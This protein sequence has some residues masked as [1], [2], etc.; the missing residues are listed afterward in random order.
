MT[1]TNETTKETKQAQPRAI[2]NRIDIYESG[3]DVPVYLRKPLC[4]QCGH[5][6]CY[7]TSGVEDR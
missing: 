5:L 2:T 6:Y 7:C 1:T 3:Y 4:P